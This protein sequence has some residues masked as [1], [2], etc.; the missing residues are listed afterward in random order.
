MNTHLAAR[1]LG[2]LIVAATPAFVAVHAQQI[3]VPQV[4]QQHSEW[5]WAADANAVLSYRGV[6]STQCGIANW[7]DSI[8]Y[9]CENAPFDWDDAANSPNA[10]TG[11]TG[12][13]GILWSLGR[14]DSHYYDGPLAFDYT[15]ASVNQGDPVVVLWTWPDG[16]GHFVVINGYDAAENALYFMNPWPG[17]GSGYG[18]Y[19][20]MLN[21]SG[22]MGTHTWAESLV[23]Y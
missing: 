16:G 20:W 13:S 23:V 12:I 22:N 11:T 17:E 18:D 19:D 4:T 10:I 8:G 1:L 15:I 14:R 9:A 21:G 3:D 7:V 5:C 2:R 6:T